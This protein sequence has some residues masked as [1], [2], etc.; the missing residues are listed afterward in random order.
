MNLSKIFLK[1]KAFA[2]QAR[3]VLRDTFSGIKNT[4]LDGNCSDI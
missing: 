3:V 1:Q 2:K 4:D